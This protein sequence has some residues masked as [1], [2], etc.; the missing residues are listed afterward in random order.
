MKRK[1]TI[2][3]LRI[4]EFEYDDESP[5][6]LETL[7]DV[8]E[9]EG[10]EDSLQILAHEINAGDGVSEFHRQTYKGISIE[11]GCDMD[12]CRTYPEFPKKEKKQ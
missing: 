10:I 2:E 9:G 12:S 4:I 3:F 1:T 8:F 5:E 7:N 6:F 11:E